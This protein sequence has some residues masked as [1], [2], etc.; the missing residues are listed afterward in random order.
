MVENN[1]WYCENC[2]KKQRAKKKLEIYHTPKILIIQIKRFSHVNKI[3]TKVDFPLKD[4]DLSK[5]I[6]SK[7]KTKSIKYDL[8]AVA[9]HYGSLT[10]GHYTAFCKNSIDEKWYE[11]NDSCVYEITDLSKIVSS[12]AYVLFYKQ[13]GLSKLNWDEIYK[14]RFVDI[15]IN[16][17]ETL[18]DYNND[19][20]NH[21][22][23]N[24]ENDKDD[25]N[26]FDK[27]IK[28]IMAKI[29]ENRNCENSNNKMEME[30]WTK[31]NTL[32]FWW[33]KR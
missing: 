13:Q 14:K 11:F 2:K 26:E 28:M 27:K 22:C 8:F 32:F 9:N 21:M 23:N 4:L 20:L 18:V 10:Y 15:D 16:I 25:I 6:L 3:N 12:N 33:N 30:N 5:Y 1:E 7:D 19:F 24:N 31:F 17:P 29:D